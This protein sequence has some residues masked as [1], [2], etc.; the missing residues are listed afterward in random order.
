MVRIGPYPPLM[1]PDPPPPT[2]NI[3]LTASAAPTTPEPTLKL[4]I[5]DHTYAKIKTE[6]VEGSE[7]I[8]VVSIIDA[9]FEAES[10]QE[11]FK[12]EL[13]NLI[14]YPK[15]KQVIL[16]LDG[17]ETMPN[18]VAE[19]M[20]SFNFQLPHEGKKSLKLCKVSSVIVA[21][22]DHLQIKDKFE[23]YEDW[24]SAYKSF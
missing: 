5:F 13:C 19:A 1:H 11:R 18:F 6:L 20:K 21:L 3:A 16:N 7:G 23:F 24:Q 12:N 4:E 14:R 9:N 15:I 8:Y 2:G 22:L 17:V 10:A